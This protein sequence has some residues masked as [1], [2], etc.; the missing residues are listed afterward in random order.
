MSDSIKSADDI[1]K[2]MHRITDDATARPVFLVLRKRVLIS[3]SAYNYVYFDEDDIS[4]FLVNFEDLSMK[5]N[6]WIVEGEGFVEDDEFETYM[7]SHGYNYHLDDDINQLVYWRDDDEMETTE[8]ERVFW[9]RDEANAYCGDNPH[10]YSYSVMAG[11]VLA[12]LMDFTCEREI[13]RIA[14]K[15]EGRTSNL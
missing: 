12:E 6:D 5:L 3:M 15:R 9:T 14:A 13:E 4:E 1:I 11:G 2:K 7:H 10:L 8:V